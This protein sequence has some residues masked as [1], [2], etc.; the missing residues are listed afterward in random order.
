[1][2]SK[3]DITSWIKNN[4]NNIVI[5]NV[6]IVGIVTLGVRALGFFKEIVIADSF[7]LSEL[8]DTFYIAILIPTFMSNVFLGGFKSVFIPNY[9]IEL[10]TGKNVGAFQSTCFI[11]TIGVSILFC[12]IAILVTDTYLDFFFKGHTLQYY[13]LI[14][15]QFYYVIPSIIFWGFSSMLSGLLNIDD[16]FKYSSASVIF[17]PIVM[18]I[19]IFFFKEQLGEI[20]LAFGTLLGSILSFIFLLIV[21]IKRNIIHLKK[22]DFVSNNIIELF[23]QLPAKLASNI[24]T[25]VN[26]I[27]DQYFAAQLVI[28]SIAA[29]NYGV[30]IPMFAIGII[31]LA[32]GNVLLPYFS[33]KVL[34]NREKAFNELKRILKFL[35]YSSSAIALVLILLSTPLI[36]LFFERNAFTN[37]DTI[38][39]SQIQQMYLIQIPAYITGIIM[40]RFLESLNRNAFMVIAA[41]MCLV[42]NIV[43]NYFLIKHLGVLG[44]ALATS[45]VC[46][47]NSLVLYLYIQH[48]NKIKT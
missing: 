22:P 28:G 26:T 38:I 24:L 18:I 3:K 47:I 35:I 1:M 27:V 21:S 12:I 48:L 37:S 13:V 7:G 25:G 20:V 14:K 46:I 45:L 23:Q 34:E 44:L 10:K 8:I 31:T 15:K 9:V 5:K 30:K 43:L 16:E 4:L 39:V 29:L 42:L 2:I 17:T 36:S 11:I 40:V 32:L 41:V 6:L 19:C 33:K